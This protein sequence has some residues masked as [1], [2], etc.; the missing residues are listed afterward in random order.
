MKSIH[1]IGFIILA[2]LACSLSGCSKT[3]YVSGT[4]TFED[5]SP[6][7]FGSVSL[8]SD[9]V[10]AIGAI[11]KRGFYSI[12]T[13]KDGSGA[14]PGHYRVWLVGTEQSSFS[15]GSYRIIPRVDHEF[16]SASSTKMA[17][18]LTPGK[19]TYNITVRKPGN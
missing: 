11:D 12:G 14:P 2:A 15:D 1:N 4:V 9:T 17:I 13:Q 10:R 6:V 8:E 3:G 19:Q 18:D 7:T 16:T 5:G